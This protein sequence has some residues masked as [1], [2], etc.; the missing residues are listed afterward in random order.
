MAANVDTVNFHGGSIS[1]NVTR[2]MVYIC[3]KFHDATYKP[4]IFPHICWTIM[5]NAKKKRKCN[6]VEIEIHDELERSCTV[7]RTQCCCQGDITVLMEKI[8]NQTKR[9]SNIYT[10]AKA[11]YIV[12]V[13]HGSF[14]IESSAHQAQVRPFLHEETF[15]SHGDYS[16]EFSNWCI[17]F[18]YRRWAQ[19]WKWRLLP[20]SSELMYTICI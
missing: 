13:S 4:T 9:T 1:E 11:K 12:W 7:Y 3:A 20:W 15:H 5:S 10:V 6:T 2:V 14:H 18:V 19:A 16:R 17:P 8:Y